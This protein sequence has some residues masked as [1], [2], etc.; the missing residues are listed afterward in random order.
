M[1]ENLATSAGEMTEE[2]AKAEIERIK[3][4]MQR[5]FDQMKCDREEGRRIAARTDAKM[6]EVQAALARLRV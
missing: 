6:A 2:Q 3:I 4:E 5:L 1:N